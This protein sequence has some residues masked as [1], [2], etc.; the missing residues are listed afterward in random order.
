[1]RKIVDENC[2][3]TFVLNT[4]NIFWQYPNQDCESCAQH[5]ASQSPHT[6]VAQHPPHGLGTSAQNAMRGREAQDRAS[7]RIKIAISFR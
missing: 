3:N 1:M 5:T 7:D 2:C 4:C 6:L